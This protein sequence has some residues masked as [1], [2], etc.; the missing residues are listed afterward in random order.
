MKTRVIARLDAKPPYIAKP[1]F[2]EGLRKVGMPEELALKYSSANADEICYIDIYSSLCDR[3]IKLEPIRAVAS[4]ILIPFAV[5]G[6]IRSIDDMKAL[7]ANGADKVIINSYAVMQDPSIIDKAESLFGSQAIT[8][9][10][11]A[12]RKDLWWECY[13]DCG[14]N[15]TG[16]NVLDWA[17]EVEKRGA[18]EILLSSI[19][20]DGAKRGFDSELIRKVN[21]ITTIPLIAGSGAGSI[22]HITKMASIA[23]PSAVALATVLHDDIVTIKEV[24]DALNGEKG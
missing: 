11:D 12:K 8:I 1:I 4:K 19:D 22:E 23:K 15:P 17:L 16:K 2:F 13:A 6:G 7:F 3:E 24:Q 10:I 14:K 9:Q 5:G 20:H 21:E 18:G